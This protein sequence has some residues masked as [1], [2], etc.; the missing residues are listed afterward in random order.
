MKTFFSFVGGE[1]FWCFENVFN[2]FIIYV[3]TSCGENNSI[4]KPKQFFTT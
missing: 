2:M 3:H 1:K 4:F